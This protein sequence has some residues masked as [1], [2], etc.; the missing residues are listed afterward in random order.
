M[1]QRTALD[2]CV[3]KVE[4]TGSRRRRDAALEGRAGDARPRWQRPASRTSYARPRICGCRSGRGRWSF[5]P[6]RSPSGSTR[7]ST[8]SL[9]VNRR[10]DRLEGARAA[11]AAAAHRSRRRVGALA[12]LR[13]AV[14]KAWPMQT[15]DSHWSTSCCPGRRASAARW[16]VADQFLVD[17]AN[18]LLN[19]TPFTFGHVVVDEAQDHS[20]VALRV[21]RAAQPARIDDDPRRPGPVDDARPGQQ[22]WD[23]ALLAHPRASAAEVVAHLTIGYRVPG[24]ILDVANRLL[25]LTD[26]RSVAEHAACAPRASRPSFG[27]CRPPTLARGGCRRGRGREASPPQHRRR[28]TDRDC[29]SRSRRR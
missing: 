25:P 13:A 12:E 18:S 17:E 6:T 14:G 29:P 10:R 28:R 3:P 24:P 4:I 15:A 19:G 5:T 22:D 11:R 27:S 7:R 26:V 23:E 16:T 9:P 2:L 1:Q 21:D 20:A 8:V